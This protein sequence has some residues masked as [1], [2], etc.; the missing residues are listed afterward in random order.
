[1]GRALRRARSLIGRLATRG[2]LLTVGLALMISLIDDLLDHRLLHATDLHAHWDLELLV[3][4]A[5]MLIVNATQEALLCIYF[6]WHHYG[7]PDPLHSLWSDP[8]NPAHLINR[9]LTLLCLVWAAHLRVSLQASKNN[10]L[11]LQ[12]QTEEKLVKSL[13]T[14]ALA[15]ELRQPLSH[16]LL[17]TQLLQFKVE[18]TGLAEPE[19]TTRL[20]ELRQSGRQ[21]NNVIAAITRLLRKPVEARA[22]V[23]LCLIVRRSLR[24]LQQGLHDASVS[25]RRIGLDH[26]VWMHGDAVQLQMACSNLLN[27]ALTALQEAPQDQRRLQIRLNRGSQTLELQVADS[28]PGLQS[29]NAHQLMMNGSSSQGMG[30][31]LLTVQTIARCHGGSLKL[32]ESKELGGAEVSLT[33]P[34]VTDSSAG[35]GT[36]P[37]DE[38]TQRR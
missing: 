5:G 8:D 29:D 19:I 7:I 12:A 32:G 33:L 9:S 23:D 2:W 14:C 34:G 10:L 28:G 13:Q 4:A 36:E 18:Q 21:V 26:P 22:L 35:I 3:L 1:M 27:N 38:P 6:L 37:P 20:E 30:L 16:L 25:V 31:G 11:Q 17:Q 15:H 24:H